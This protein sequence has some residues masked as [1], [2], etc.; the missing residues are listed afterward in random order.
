MKSSHPFSRK[1]Y[2]LLHS[3]PT[4]LHPLPQ[5]SPYKIDYPREEKS[6]EEKLAEKQRNEEYYR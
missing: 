2:S 3:P 6:V 5:F 4:A 1:R